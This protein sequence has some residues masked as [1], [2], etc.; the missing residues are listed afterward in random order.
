M[1][2]SSRRWNR[3]TATDYGSRTT[4]AGLSEES[5]ECERRITTLHNQN[6][7]LNRWEDTTQER[8]VCC[9][10]HNIRTN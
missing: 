1:V 2:D 5:A 9:S 6:T 10:G 8:T 3:R 4:H 7:V